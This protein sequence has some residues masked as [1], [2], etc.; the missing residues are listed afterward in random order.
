MRSPVVVAII[1]ASLLAISGCASGSRAAD[2]SATPAEASPLSGELTV[3]A[4]ASL[5]TAFDEITEQF[6]SE[7]PGVDVLPIVYDG[8]EHAGDPDHRGGQRRRVRLSR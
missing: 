7:N 3:F 2:A 6:E 8:L 5:K 4:A 1:V